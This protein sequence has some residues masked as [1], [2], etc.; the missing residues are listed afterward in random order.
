MWL[1]LEVS[2]FMGATVGGFNA[3]GCLGWAC[4]QSVMVVYV[5]WL[6][7]VQRVKAVVLRGLKLQC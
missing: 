4:N 3:P 6:S 7:L 1:I 5:P 2:L